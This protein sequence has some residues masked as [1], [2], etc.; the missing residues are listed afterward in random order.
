MA[1][2]LAAV[3]LG[4]CR[5]QP[6]EETAV[7]FQRQPQNGE[8]PAC[9]GVAGAP[10]GSMD[11]YIIEVWEFDDPSIISA[12]P[13]IADCERCIAS[14]ASCHLEQRVCH[15]DKS[16]QVT[17][18]G[19]ATSL[20]G[21]RVPNVDSEYL[22]CMRVIAIDRGSLTAS[23]QSDCGGCDPEWITQP[24]LTASARMCSV[25]VPRGTG[26][27]GVPVTVICP[28]DSNGR[29]DMGTQSPFQQCLF[30]PPS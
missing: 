18:E 23:P 21:V 1:A 5:N 30:P 4:G 13:R 3:L 9:T 16:S 28:G 14:P 22:Y 29:Q 20:Q 25:S 8:Q 26:P 27:L 2:A 24:F 15:C 6:V 19:L 10:A 17:A 7:M 12:T 11:A